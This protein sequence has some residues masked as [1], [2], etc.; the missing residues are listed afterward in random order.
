MP[1][2]PFALDV[3]ALPTG[4]MAL[5][6]PPTKDSGYCPYIRLNGIWY[7]VNSSG[8]AYASTEESVLYMMQHYGFK[9][10]FHG[11]W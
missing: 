10:L 2:A 3:T 9:P 6:G 5:V 8:S 11:V 7:E 4:E 1:S